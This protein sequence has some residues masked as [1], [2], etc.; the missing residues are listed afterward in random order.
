MLATQSY[1]LSSVL[2]AL[3]AAWSYLVPCQG[4]HIRASFSPVTHR[5]EWIRGLS[6]P[7]DHALLP[8]SKDWNAFDLSN[9]LDG[10]QERV[11]PDMRYIPRNVQR[12]SRNYLALR[13]VGGKD[14]VHDIYVRDPR[15]STFWFVG[16]VACVSGVTIEDCIA[17]QWNLIETHAVNLR[18]LDLFPARGV[19]EMW[20]APGDSELDVAYNRP[21][22][23][24]TKHFRSL[25]V[26][27][28]P[29]K[30]NLVGFQGEVYE[31]GEEGFRTWRLE[32]GLPAR[33]QVQAPSDDLRAPTDEEMEEIRE[34]LSGKDINE[35]YE[36]QQRRDGKAT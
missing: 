18:P 8:S 36:E 16:K 21:D 35:I 2:V 22:I 19:L 10:D 15:S 27:S 3:V 30:S 23:A 4:R 6:S 28:P 1:S 17:R 34:A 5:R 13:Q 9:D 12:Q 7:L 11:L 20:S 29:I 26:A 33:P 32:N 14:V 25:D 24:F 31:R